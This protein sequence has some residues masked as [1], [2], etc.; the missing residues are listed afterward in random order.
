M[1]LRLHP[2][3]EAHNAVE[4]SGDGILNMLGLFLIL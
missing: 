1:T 3:I 4:L 2:L